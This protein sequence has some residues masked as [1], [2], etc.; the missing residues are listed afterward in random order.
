M[1]VAAHLVVPFNVTIDGEQPTLED[2]A[3]SVLDEL[4]EL[5]DV[6][7]Q[8]LDINLA[9]SVVTFEVLAR[10]DTPGEAIDRG[11]AAIRTAIHAAGS[12]THGWNEAFYTPTS[13]SPHAGSWEAGTLGISAEP[14]TA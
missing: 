10:G 9:T 2:L 13:A 14:V 6:T 5:D 12:H 7:D 8:T 3:F 4:M 1:P 11:L